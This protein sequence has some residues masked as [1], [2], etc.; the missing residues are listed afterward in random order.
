MPDL[1]THAAVGWL[2]GRALARRRPG[3]WSVAAFV[4][5]S[6][7]PD[8]LSRV[9]TLALVMLQGRVGPLPPALLNAFE[10][11]HTPLGLALAAWGLAFLF[12][13]DQ[14][15]AVLR[16]L[17]GGMALHLFLD[18]LQDHQGVGL[19]LL[20]PLSPRLFELGWIGS[21]SSVY[22]APF[23]AVLVAVLARRDRRRPATR[24]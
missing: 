8:L 1:V 2:A 15:P 10:P 20:Y 16:G 23:L 22:A 13:E 19:P 5:G 18:L 6:Y 17:L 14:R 11:L 21:E 3:R 24:A 12:R 4:A 9:P 7:A